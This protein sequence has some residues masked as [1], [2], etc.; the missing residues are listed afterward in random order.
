[1]IEYELI[2]VT[3]LDITSK[4]EPWIDL[5]EVREMKPAT[6][7]SVGWLIVDSESFITVASTLDCIDDI[8]GDVNC[9]PQS[10]VLLV[11]PVQACEA[12]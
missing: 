1:M 11:E 5:D 7:V 8:A 6:M 10:T 4:S 9:I 12:N 3:W 2:K